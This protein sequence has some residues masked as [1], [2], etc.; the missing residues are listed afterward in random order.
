MFEKLYVRIL[1]LQITSQELKLRRYLGDVLNINDAFFW[2]NIKTLN[3]RFASIQIL[4]YKNFQLTT[5]D[6]HKSKIDIT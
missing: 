3:E 6:L 5:E 1:K 4:I 2:D